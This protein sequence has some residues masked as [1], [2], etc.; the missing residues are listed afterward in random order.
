MLTFLYAIELDCWIMF[1][2]FGLQFKEKH[3]REISFPR[4][5][6]ENLYKNKLLRGSNHMIATH[7]SQHTFFLKKFKN[8]SPFRWVTDTPVLDF[9]SRLPWVSKPGWIP[10]YSFLA[11]VTLRFTLGV[12]LRFTSGVTPAGVSMAAEPFRSTYLQTCSPHT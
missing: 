11:C 3:F 6:S 4:T 1:L 9:Y 5:F 12:T 8:I 7:F 10:F 2:L